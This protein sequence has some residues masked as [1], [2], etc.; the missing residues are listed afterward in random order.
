MGYKHI[1]GNKMS[2]MMIGL[3]KSFSEK[4]GKPSAVEKAEVEQD[5]FFMANGDSGDEE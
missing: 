1:N 3:T 2:A 5:D 4:A